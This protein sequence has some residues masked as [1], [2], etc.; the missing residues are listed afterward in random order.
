MTTRQLV[1]GIVL[2]EW[3]DEIV[4]GLLDEVPDEELRR[5][6]IRIANY[7]AYGYRSV[8]FTYGYKHVLNSKKVRQH[9][10]RNLV[11]NLRPYVDLTDVVEPGPAEVA[12]V[13]PAVFELV[14][15]T[16]K[17]KGASN[18]SRRRRTRRVG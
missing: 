3:E 11:L 2:T 16:K 6:C 17:T 18:V 5:A 15:P 7:A 10:L 9:F 14:I 8:V 4:E 1:W 13:F 12:A